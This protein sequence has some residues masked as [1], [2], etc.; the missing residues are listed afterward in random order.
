MVGIPLD[1]IRLMPN[2]VPSDVPQVR[3][4]HDMWNEEIH[5]HRDLRIKAIAATLVASGKVVT[6]TDSKG[7]EWI[8]ATIL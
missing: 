5:K 4:L 3:Q 2:P 6:Y 8:D 1:T 7:I